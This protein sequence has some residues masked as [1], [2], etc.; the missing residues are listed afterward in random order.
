MMNHSLIGRIGVSKKQ[1]VIGLDLGAAFSKVVIG[2]RLVR[3]AVPFGEFAHPANPYLLPSLLNID[4][5]NH[6]ALTS[7]DNA[8]DTDVNLKSPLLET[9]GSDDDYLR[10]VAY[11]ALVFRASKSWL[12]ERYEKRYGGSELSWSINASLPADSLQPRQAE[13]YRQILY[14][15]WN[16]SVLPGPIT[17]NRVRQFMDIDEAAFDAFPAVYRSRLVANRQVNVFS[18][19][20]AQ[21]CGYVHS[22]KCRND[23]HMLID[24]G[25]ESISIATFMVAR[26][27]ESRKGSRC[28]LY[29]C[30]TEAVGVSHLLKRRYENLQLPETGINLFKDIPDNDAFAQAHDLTEKDIKFAD[31]LYSGDAAKL[32]SRVMDITKKQYCTDSTHWDNGVLTF[33]YGGGARLEIVQ[34]ILHRF[35]SKPPPHRITPINLSAPDDLMVEHLP[36]GSYDR[37]SIAY[38]LSFVADDIVSVSAKDPLAV[39]EAT[40]VA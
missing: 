25:A 31:T 15:A 13:R 9:D 17:L 34:C 24:V 7:A 3:Y 10:I 36:E 8:F 37:L 4:K 30:A 39:N 29:A 12:L 26:D 14:S 5:N 21:I 16:L 22:K 18:A 32:I 33:T 1:L 40:T 28:T 27:D 2:D 20:N 23:L 38:G 6:C 19:C 35:E 11:L